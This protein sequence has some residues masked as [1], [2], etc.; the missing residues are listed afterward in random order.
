MHH[1]SREQLQKRSKKAINGEIIHTKRV[2][3]IGDGFARPL[4]TVG[5]AIESSGRVVSELHLK[6][7]N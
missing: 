6:K 2:S 5:A 1:S 7:L 4:G 3:I